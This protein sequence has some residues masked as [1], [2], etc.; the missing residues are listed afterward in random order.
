[1]YQLGFICR[2]ATWPQLA[3]RLL[4]PCTP[5]AQPIL[6]RLRTVAVSAYMPVTGTAGAYGDS[7]FKFLRNLQT[8]STAAVPFYIPTNNERE[9]QFLY[10]LANT[11]S[12]VVV[13]IVVILMDNVGLL[14][15]V[16]QEMK[17]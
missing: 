11:C 4:P 9:F 6:K 5:S 1:M 7:M 10:I 2:A 14:C 17:T 13:F 16:E 15:L 12:F 3:L 8:V